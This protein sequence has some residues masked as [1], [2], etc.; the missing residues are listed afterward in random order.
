MPALRRHFIFLCS[1][2]IKIDLIYIHRICESYFFDDD[3]ITTI[4]HDDKKSQDLYL[5]HQINKLYTFDWIFSQKLD[6]Y[7]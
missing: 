3:Y 2:K 7:L 6:M 5:F 1:V 4:I